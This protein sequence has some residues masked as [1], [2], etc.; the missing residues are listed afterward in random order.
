MKLFKTFRCIATFTLL[1]SPSAIFCQL[2][3]KVGVA[4]Q[5]ITPCSDNLRS[6]NL[7]KP[8]YINVTG[9]I[10]N[11]GGN[12]TT[13]TSVESDLEVRAVVIQDIKLNRVALITI[14]NL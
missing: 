3:F 14:D 7:C 6:N 12:A 11:S 2:V 9:N 10:K 4:T 8:E 13:I 1:I 5:N